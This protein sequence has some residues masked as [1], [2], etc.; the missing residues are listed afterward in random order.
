MNE[1]LPTDDIERQLAR[2]RPAEPPP[3][4]IARLRA[5]RP[6]ARSLSSLEPPVRVTAR[7]RPFSPALT[8]A[9]AIALT[10]ALVWL[11]VPASNR[12]R[13]STN[14][15]LTTADPVA[16]AARDAGA[17]PRPASVP[18]TSVFL[19]VEASS[20]VVS[21]QPV[22]ATLR[23]DE[24]ARPFWRA[25]VIDDLTAVGAETD[26]ALHWRRA[27]ELYIPVTSPVY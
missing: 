1:R 26:A 6:E 27:R 11:S 12:I 19:P 23:P 15:P 24:V 8:A 22:S 7:P 5:A 4:L 13:P 21:M 9:A 14:P 25:L 10:A 18:A 16:D 2:L 3:A 20:R 17:E